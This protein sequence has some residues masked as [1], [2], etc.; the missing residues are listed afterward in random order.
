MRLRQNPD[1]AERTKRAASVQNGETP[2]GPHGCP[3]ALSVRGHLLTQRRFSACNK[4]IGTI[5]PLRQDPFET[6]VSEQLVE[7]FQRTVSPARFRPYLEAAGFD[8][9]RAIRFY[10]WNVMIGQSFHFPLQTVEVSL[11]NVVNAALCKVSGENWWNHD[12]AKYLLD[13]RRLKDLDDI[14]RRLI[15]RGLRITPDEMVA[16][17][18]FGFWT[19]VIAGKYRENIWNKHQGETFPG[20]PHETNFSEAY[21][22]AN[23]TLGLRNAVF[24]HEIL[25]GRDLTGEYSAMMKLLGWICP[26]THA[27][28]KEHCS[29]PRVLREKPK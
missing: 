6:V 3:G 19:G 13:D 2:G 4:S 23:K 5:M 18:S 1:G 9:N 14:Q 29:V 15:T 16:G 17:L 26:E 28:V 8:Q 10:L 24:H 25:I 7:S 21:A 27:W 12:T 11:R 22:Q 20:M